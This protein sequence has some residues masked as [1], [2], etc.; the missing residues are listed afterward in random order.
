MPRQQ[1]QLTH[2]GMFTDHQPIPFHP[3]HHLI[4]M[5]LSFQRLFMIHLII[6]TPFLSTFSDD[7]TQPH[8]YCQTFKGS[9]LLTEHWQVSIHVS[10]ALN[11]VFIFVNPLAHQAPNRPTPCEPIIQNNR[12]SQCLDGLEK[13]IRE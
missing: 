3:G 11:P 9:T 8:S 5:I 4:M 1:E 13:G 6:Q 10:S 7:K 12:I 2:K